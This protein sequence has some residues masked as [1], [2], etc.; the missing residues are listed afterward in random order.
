MLETR[1]PDP[2]ACPTWIDWFVGISVACRRAVLKH[3]NAA[4][5]LLQFMP[6]DLLITKYEVGV[7]ILAEIGLP[8]S[9]RIPDRSV[10]YPVVAGR[11]G[12]ER[13][14]LQPAFLP[15]ITLVLRTGGY[16]SGYGQDSESAA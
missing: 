4:P 7:Q 12:R 2:A 11:G 15:L 13:G 10:P 3:R 1:L 9:Q 16:C 5:V 8:P 14:S 6:R